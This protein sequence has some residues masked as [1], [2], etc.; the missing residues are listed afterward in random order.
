MSVKD[1]N[2]IIDNLPQGADV[3][4]I[5]DILMRSND[6]SGPKFGHVTVDQAMQIWEEYLPLLSQQSGL[7][8]ENI[9]LQVS[10]ISPV[11]DTYDLVGDINN[12]E[13]ARMTSI[14]L[15]VGT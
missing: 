10:N 8:I 1:K 15:F 2:T 9:S 5:F 12:S 14:K 3:D 13:V 6:I 4:K 7:P 11:K